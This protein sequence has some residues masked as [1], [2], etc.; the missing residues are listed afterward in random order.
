MLRPAD[1]LEFGFAFRTPKPQD[2]KF[3]LYVIES[4]AAG[5]PVVLPDTAS[6][7][8]LIRETGGGVVCGPNTPA[9]LVEALEPLLLNPRRLRELGE[10]GRA[11]VRGRFN[12][13]AM[14]REVSLAIAELT[15]RSPSSV[16]SRTSTRPD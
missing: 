6:F 8:E 10:A 15:H 16:S 11:S 7:P 4:M 9:A 1:P 13:D 5:T 3:G 12:D 14:A 2:S